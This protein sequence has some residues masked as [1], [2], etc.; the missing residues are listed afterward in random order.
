MYGGFGLTGDIGDVQL[1][2]EGNADDGGD[3]NAMRG[4]SG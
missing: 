1:D 3:A 4:A 2:D